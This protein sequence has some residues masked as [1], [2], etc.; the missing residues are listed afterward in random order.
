M[1]STDTSR[2]HRAAVIP[3]RIVLLSILGL[4][5]CYYGL[6][7]LSAWV[8][9]FPYQSE[10]A[11]LRAIVALAGIVL[12][13]GLWSII[14]L[15]DSRPFWVKVTV[16]LVMAFPL[17]LAIAKINNVVFQDIEAQ[18]ERDVGERSGVNLR[19]D[20]AGNII[21]DVPGMPGATEAE[22]EAGQQT[23]TIEASKDGNPAWQELIYMAFGRYFMLLAWCALYFALL[24]GERARVAERRAGE[25]RQAAKA[26]ELRSLRYQVNPHFLFNT[27]N[28]LSALILT[29]KNEQAEQMVQTIANFYRQSLTDD[30]TSDLALKEEFDLQRLYLQIESARFPDRLR[31]EYDLPDGLAEQRIPGMILQP[32]VENS[33]K[34]A[35]APVNRPVTISIS[36]REEYGRLVLTVADNGPGVSDA[37]GHGYGIG[38]DNVRQRLEARFGKE[39][40]MVSGPSGDGYA[41]HVR[42]PMAPDTNR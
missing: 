29:N 42:I 22:Q 14:R 3:F 25:F 9:G 5:A 17:A 12:T 19:R 39:A 36:A 11:G 13:L 6:T 35:V 1:V 37:N 27:L 34:Y 7:T 26:A 33:V 40:H 16:A 38:L 41:T 15:F 23:I 31:A 30:P 10:M 8:G 21:I 2:G 4:W 18:I 20:R 32:L 24:A 28:S